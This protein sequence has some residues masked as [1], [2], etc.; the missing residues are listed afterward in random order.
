[1]RGNGD[2]DKSRLRG[3]D[4]R[5]NVRG[6][7]MDDRDINL[8]WDFLVCFTGEAKS[9]GPPTISSIPGNRGP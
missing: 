1:M 6:D 8:G 9:I 5:S 3:R 2:G 4:I 7:R